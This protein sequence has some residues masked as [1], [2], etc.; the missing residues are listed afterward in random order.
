MRARW[1]VPVA[2]SLLL[3]AADGFELEPIA[4]LEPDEYAL[5]RLVPMLDLAAQGSGTAPVSRMNQPRYDPTHEQE[6]RP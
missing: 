3:S 5:D 4:A 1:S 2:V 6:H